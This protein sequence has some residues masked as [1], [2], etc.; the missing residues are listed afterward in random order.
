[1]SESLSAGQYY[2]AA[3]NLSLNSES[4]FGQH[5]VGQYSA[6]ALES[7]VNKLSFQT[8]KKHKQ[9]EISRRSRKR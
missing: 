9:K 6:V 3:C 1:M 4:Q 8:S 2:C 7:F 5:Q